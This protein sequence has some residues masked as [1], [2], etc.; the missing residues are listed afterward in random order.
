MV[1]KD[2]PNIGSKFSGE[3]GTGALGELTVSTN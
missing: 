3:S 1:F 2:D